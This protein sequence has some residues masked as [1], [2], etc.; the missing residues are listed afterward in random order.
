MI[1]TITMFSIW[2][3]AHITVAAS[4]MTNEVDRVDSIYPS[5]PLYATVL[6][7]IRAVSISISAFPAA[8]V[9]IHLFYKMMQIIFATSSKIAKLKRTDD[10]EFVTKLHRKLMIYIVISI[11]ATVM[12]ILGAMLFN[13]IFDA[14]VY[15]GWLLIL[16]N[17]LR[18]IRDGVKQLDDWELQ[19]RNRE[20]NQEMES[21][22]SSGPGESYGMPSIEPMGSSFQ[23]TNNSGKK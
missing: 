18:A 15:A 5:R 13:S 12:Q 3:L 4:G 11:V 9:A 22:V 19:S 21:P 17:L 14:F 2:A 8:F 20:S 6:R 23:S 10:K 7:N 1:Y 16:M